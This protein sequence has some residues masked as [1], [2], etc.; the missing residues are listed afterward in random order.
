MARYRVLWAWRDGALWETAITE[1]G[2]LVRG[3]V[4][5]VPPSVHVICRMCGDTMLRAEVTPLEHDTP[6]QWS[7]RIAVCET[8]PPNIL[9]RVPGSVWREDDLGYLTAMPE[10]L[11]SRECRLH[12][13]HME[14]LQDD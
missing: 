3:T 9:D 12:F 13:K 7:A 11:L 14:N 6:S 8:C 4:H 5:L 1:R 10:P 2:A